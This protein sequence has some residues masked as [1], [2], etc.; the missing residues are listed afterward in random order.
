MRDLS[1]SIYRPTGVAAVSTMSSSR[2]RRAPPTPAT[3]VSATTV[4]VSRSPSN[5]PGDSK[6]SLRLTVHAPSN[7]LA[8]AT[9]KLR[10]STGPASLPPDQSELARSARTSRAK[11]PVVEE[12]LSDEEDDDE[13]MEE[14]ED[15]EGEDE[16]EEMDA[17][18]NEDE[19]GEDDNDPVMAAP[20]PPPPVMTRT[21][22][23]PNPKLTVTPAPAIVPLGPVEAKQ[24]TLAR[25]GMSVSPAP[26]SDEELSE[27]DDEDAEGEEVDEDEEM[28]GMGGD[29]DAEGESDDEMNR[30]G[31]ET[32]DISKMTKR[33]RERYIAGGDDDGFLALPMGKRAAMIIG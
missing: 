17:D 7:K 4:T 24:M 2:T 14:D 18:S 9:S 10:D 27:L 3:P 1:D 22:P 11:K 5:S 20:G 13:E 33:Q 29:E 15:A 32:P 31:S 25:K 30:D 23:L 12:S 21:G 16:D 19:E 6:K 26:T 28:A 8:A